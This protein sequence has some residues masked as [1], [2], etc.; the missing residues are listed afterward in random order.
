MREMD[1]DFSARLTIL[2]MLVAGVYADSLYQMPEEEAEK[3]IVFLSRLGD[4]V[5]VSEES[6]PE[7]TEKYGMELAQLVSQ[8]MEK[9]AE[10]IRTKQAELRE[11]KS[12]VKS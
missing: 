10:K 12:V 3:I 8:K 11:G 6:D 5:T 1:K 7:G 9:F 4:S 2:E